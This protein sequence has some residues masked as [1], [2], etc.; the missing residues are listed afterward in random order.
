MLSGL[1]VALRKKQGCIRP[2]AV[3]CTLRCLVAKIASRSVMEEMA[4]LL[5]PRQL[6]YGIQGGAEAAADAARFFSSSHA[7]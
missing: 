3:G 7:Q 1:L 6:G 4:D 2:I 5:S